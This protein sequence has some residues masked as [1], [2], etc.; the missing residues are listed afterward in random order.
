MLLV[1]VY[2]FSG[3]Y[4]DAKR[5][6]L[7][8]VNQFR[9]VLLSFI[10]QLL[11]TLFAYYQQN[12]R[13]K[14]LYYH[15]VIDAEELRVRPKRLVRTSIRAQIWWANTL[16][17]MLPLL[18]VL[19]YFYVFIA[20][21]DP[22]SYTAEQLTALFGR[23]GPLVEDTVFGEPILESIQAG[24][25]V[26]FL[27]NMVFFNAIDTMIMLVG[28]CLGIAVTFVYSYLIA[29]WSIQDIILPLKELQ[30]NINLAAGGDLSQATPVRSNDEIG[31]LTENFNR[32]LV[33]LRETARL[34][35]AKEAA[36]SANVAKSLFLANMSHELRT[37]LNAILGFTQLMSKDANLTLEQHENIATI[38]RS[39][40]HLLGLINDVLDMSKIESG[41]I[42]LEVEAFDLHAL[43]ES[44]EGMFNLRAA[45]KG[46]NLLVEH[47]PEVPQY[48]RADQ[49]KLRQILMNLLSNAIKFTEHG[50]V[51][52]RVRHVE[53][54][55]SHE[56]H[57]EV[58]DTGI[59]I[60]Q[61]EVDALFEPF[62]QTQSGRQSS[63]GTGLGLPISRKYVDL[64]GGELTVSSVPNQGSVFKFNAR[65]ELAQESEVERIRPERRVI[66]VA[67][68]QPVYRILIAEDRDTNRLLLAKILRPL[69]FEL[70][71]A[72]NG[73]QA[74]EIWEEWEPHLVFMDMR[75][76]IMDGHEATQR[77]K[78]TTR[79]QA[80]VVIALTASAFEDQRHMVLAEGCDDYIRK[81]FR[82]HEIYDKLQRHLGVQ[83]LYEDFDQPL[84]THARP[85]DLSAEALQ[86]LPHTWRKELEDATVQGDLDR[87]LALIGD[88]REAHAEVA[89]ALSRLASDFDYQTILRLLGDGGSTE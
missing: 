56:L 50:G 10:I 54:S 39:G 12:H 28:I 51:S 76:P 61:E 80:T 45:E 70:R 4:D 7:Q 67:A 85:S 63:E 27:G 72:S 32:M 35:L 6:F 5:V 38:N 69:H 79:G 88:I 21:S 43:L 46:L 8:Y 57:F 41:K 78:S 53:L 60:A 30:A 3:F 55:G 71:E 29:K 26:L 86:M 82:D 49:S 47:T 62:V 84:A 2:T 40:E 20:V 73:Q 37:P 52:V 1:N 14:I 25:G 18:L 64:M 33:S 81:P 83:F 19:L 24:S 87:M 23:Y 89:D 65:V 13:V 77:I 15:H 17:T 58:E 74:V 44:V 75:M 31:A 9:I 68:D 34:Q 59:G 42:S 66:G 22:S 11:V 16:T 36:E 48:V